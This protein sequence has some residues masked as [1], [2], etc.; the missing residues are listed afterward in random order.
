MLMLYCGVLYYRLTKNKLDPPCRGSV[1]E[2]SGYEGIRKTLGAQ[3]RGIVNP[4]T[5]L[6]GA[7]VFGAKVGLMEVYLEM[8]L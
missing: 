4:V 6:F 2:R 5:P 8:V 3:G 1:D 7:D